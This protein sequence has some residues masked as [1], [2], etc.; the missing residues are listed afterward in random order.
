MSIIEP[1]GN[2]VIQ[3]EGV[4]VNLKQTHFPFLPAAHR[5][6]MINASTISHV[7]DMNI[8][9]HVAGFSTDVSPDAPATPFN[10]A[11][12]KIANA[13]G[14]GVTYI[15]KGEE[16]AYDDIP[17]L[18]SLNPD[19]G[20]KAE[21]ASLAVLAGHNPAL[22]SCYFDID[23]GEIGSKRTQ[24]GATL[25]VVKIQTVGSPTYQLTPFATGLSSRTPRALQ[26]QKATNSMFFWNAETDAS[27][28][29]I[30]DFLLNYLILK[31][32]PSGR[33][34]VPDTPTAGNARSRKS[35]MLARLPK[36]KREALTDVGCSNSTYP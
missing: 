13:S 26:P 6:V 30:W 9:A 10:G 8:A 29:S 4:C 14:N 34:N 3:F 25:T 36:A 19:L 28:A 18:A 31:E 17:S 32:P 16:G 23:S 27:Q 2:I 1:P 20:L 21:M 12:V 11:V 15:P 24:L 35:E 22:A 7:W 33:P 5:I